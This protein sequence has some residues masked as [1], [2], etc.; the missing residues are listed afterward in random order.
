MAINEKEIEQIEKLARDELAKWMLKVM[1]VHKVS[2]SGWAG[3]AGLTDTTV[4]RF[5]NYKKTTPSYATIAK[6]A[7]VMNEDFPTIKFKK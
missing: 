5:L 3:K 1:D 6:L 4:T 2:G 7:F